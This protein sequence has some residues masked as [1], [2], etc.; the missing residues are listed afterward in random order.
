PLSSLPL[1]PRAVMTGAVHEG[2]PSDRATAP[3]A[4]LPASP[5]C[6]RR[7]R[8][9]TSLSIDV[10]ILGVEAGAT[11]SESF[12]QHETH[13]SDQPANSLCGQRDA[14]RLRMDARGPQRFV[15][16]D[17]SDTAD[18]SLIKQHPLDR[19]GSTTHVRNEGR[20]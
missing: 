12:L 7:M 19:T 17:V 14:L 4:R 6:I 15:R 8:E 3:R 18:Q 13:L 10:H 11:L 1:T 2:L 16:I 9:V 20:I 5:V